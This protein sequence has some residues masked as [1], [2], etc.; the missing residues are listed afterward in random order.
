MS[1]KTKAWLK[2]I[3]DANHVTQEEVIAY[4]RKL[5]HTNGVIHHLDLVAPD[6]EG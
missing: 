1:N 4:L 3:A 5:S 6:A 2:R